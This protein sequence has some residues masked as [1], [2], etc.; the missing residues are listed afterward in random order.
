LG[1][2]NIEG[3]EVDHR[4]QP[5]V[6]KLSEPRPT[7]T[8]GDRLV[9]AEQCLELT[10]LIGRDHIVAGMQQRRLPGMS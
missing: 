1:I 4:A 9:A 7:A 8:G 3:G 10:L 2:V 5:R 6:L